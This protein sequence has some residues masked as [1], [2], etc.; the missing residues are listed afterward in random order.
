M[1]LMLVTACSDQPPAAKPPSPGQTITAHAEVGGFP[2][3]ITTVCQQTKP[4]AS[5]PAGYAA[6]WTETVETIEAASPTDAD[7]SR[8]MREQV[9]RLRQEYYHGFGEQASFGTHS[10][11]GSIDVTADVIA[12]SPDLVSVSIGTVYY[13]AGMSHPNSGGRQDLIWSRRLHR[14]LKQ[15]DVFAIKPDRALRLIAQARFDNRENLQNPENPD[16][17]P[18]KWHRASLGPSGITWWFDSYELGGYASA[19][20]ATIEWLVLKPYL[21]H[22]LPFAIAA[23]REASEAVR[24]HVPAECS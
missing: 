9:M 19:G 24:S 2:Y 20:S 23:I 14:P 16:G 15:D 22:D 12:A 18:L 3:K 17:I 21:R 8:F 4:V 7:F 5:A 11:A 1:L 13:E 10:E 6:T